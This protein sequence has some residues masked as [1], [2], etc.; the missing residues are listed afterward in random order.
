MAG[1]GTPGTIQGIGTGTNS[2]F[3]LQN[4]LRNKYASQAAQAS[5]DPSA[6]TP[7]NMYSAE[8]GA[9]SDGLSEARTFADGG[10]AGLMGQGNPL[11]QFNIQSAYNNYAVPNAPSLQ[12][13]Q[14]GQPN[15]P[16][17]EGAPSAPQSPQGNNPPILSNQL[18]STPQ[19]IGG[20][21]M[22]GNAPG[23]DMGF[24]KSGSDAGVGGQPVN[25]MQTPMQGTR[26]PTMSQYMTPQGLQI[27]GNPTSQMV[28]R[29]Q[30]R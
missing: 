14:Q 8:G 5:S 9:P 20:P 16:Q 25:Q 12:Y 22:T 1:G 23:E 7:Q 24:D 17:G 19:Q 27:Q 15:Q 3:L 2:P 21:D 10:I 18:P 29:P 30:Q 4:M 6:V 11:P 13:P 28:Q 26:P